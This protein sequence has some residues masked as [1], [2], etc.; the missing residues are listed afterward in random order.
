MTTTAQLKLVCRDIN[1]A[2]PAQQRA[3][4]AGVQPFVVGQ[5]YEAF[6]G[7]ETLCVIDAQGHQRIVPKDSMEWGGA[8][9]AWEPVAN[10]S[11]KS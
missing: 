2:D 5:S 9:F 10:G 8:L 6:V 4:T 3:K 1:A 7:D 11:E